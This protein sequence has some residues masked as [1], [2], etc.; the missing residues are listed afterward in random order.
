LRFA[1]CEYGGKPAMSIGMQ[2]NHQ[3]RAEIIGPLEHKLQTELNVPRIVAR[4]INST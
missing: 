3:T 1:L 4:A 2:I